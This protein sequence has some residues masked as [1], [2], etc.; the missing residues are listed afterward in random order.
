M[1]AL[2]STEFLHVPLTSD[3]DITSD[4]VSVGLSEDGPW[5]DATHEDGGV[6]VLVGPSATL[7]LL[8]GVNEIWVKI[9]DAPEVPV[10]LAGLVVAS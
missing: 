9:T 5:V 3:V 10:L 8:P 2:S 1:I 7:T 4:T 6:K